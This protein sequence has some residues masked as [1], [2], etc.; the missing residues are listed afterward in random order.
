MLAK[1]YS[2][3]KKNGQTVKELYLIRGT[4]EYETHNPDTVV[5][6]STYLNNF[7]VVGSPDGS[8]GFYDNQTI[9]DFEKD[10]NNDYA[11]YLVYAL[12]NGAQLKPGVSFS[13]F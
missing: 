1:E 8:Y 7:L 9:A 6:L 2:E 10:K 4:N 5:I 12:G 3:V 13:C 11:Y